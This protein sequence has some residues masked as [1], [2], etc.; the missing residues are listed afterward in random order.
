[1]SGSA[2]QNADVVM[3][4]AT[5]EAEVSIANKVKA[6]LRMSD[7]SVWVDR[8]TEFRYDALLSSQLNALKHADALPIDFDQIVGE[9]SQ[10]YGCNVGETDAFVGRSSVLKKFYIRDGYDALFEKIK[11]CWRDNETKRVTLIGNPGTGKS[12]FQVYVLRE[13]L[14]N[15]DGYKYIIRQVGVLIYIIDLEQI[16]A[17]NGVLPMVF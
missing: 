11:T 15:R 4:D 7:F 9:G 1:M 8:D 5:L 16:N 12:W 17:T 3:T 14:R 10:L 13:L 6:D 2:P